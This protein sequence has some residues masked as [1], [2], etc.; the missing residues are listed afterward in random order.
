VPLID[1]FNLAVG[2]I[3]MP[4]KL[5]PGVS[6]EM[7]KKMAKM[8]LVVQEVAEY[9]VLQ[10]LPA[11]DGAIISIE[12]PKHDITFVALQGDATGLADGKRLAMNRVFEVT[13]TMQYTTVI[14][15]VKTV[16]VLKPFDM[17]SVAEFLK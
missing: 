7:A 9:K 2:D 4:G 1:P 14:G 3:G 10:V 17:S 15:A 8:E 5:A 6:G 16:F 13:G 12:S 11:G